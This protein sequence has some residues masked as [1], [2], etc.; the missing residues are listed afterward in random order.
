MG[1]LDVFGGKK[2]VV[3]LDIGSSAVKLVELVDNKGSWSVAAM[4]QEGLPAEAIVD[5]AIMDATTVSEA[6]R[7]VFEQ[8]RVKSD[9]VATAVSGHAVIIKRISM[10]AMS[11]EELTESIQWEAEQYIPFDI[12]EVSLDYEIMEGPGI[13]EGTMDVL[14]VAVKRDKINDYTSAIAQ[15][16]KQ[17]VVVDIDA[18]AVQNAYELSYQ[19][20]PALSTALINIGASVTNIAIL[21]GLTPNFWRDI[22][23]GGNQY[24]DA[25]QKELNL[26]FETAEAVKRGQ[27][28]AEEIPKSS[29]EPIIQAV[30]EEMGNEL[31]KTLG[32]YKATASEEDVDRIVLSGG[33]AMVEGLQPFLHD[34]FD[35]PVELMDPFRGLGRK[36]VDEAQL[37]EMSPAL[38]VAVGLAM[39]RPG[40][41]TAA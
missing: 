14:L 4:A 32:F 1:L 23:V 27:P 38:V 24:T 26:P 41:K 17:P 33:G 12:N 21:N 2:S 30:N 18:F 8:S 6:I 10:P 34:K 31:N 39:R 15:A 3:G 36:G 19:L 22:N 7:S 13:E 9:Q 35:C 29:V 40:D 20:D 28:T 25:I 37:A 11:T 5:G 16:Q